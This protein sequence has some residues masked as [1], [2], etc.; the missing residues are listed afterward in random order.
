MRASPVVLLLALAVA[1]VH[2]SPLAAQVPDSAK[3]PQ[4]TPRA[5]PRD[6]LMAD[7]ARADTAEARERGPRWR[8]SW[9]PYLTGGA[10]D[11]PVFSFLVRHWQPA[12][13][14]AR[15]TYTGAF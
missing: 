11:S 5:A 1:S 4:A 2:P 3:A 14:E 13:Y 8:T 10:N 6:T 12:D 7:T 9:F 15:S